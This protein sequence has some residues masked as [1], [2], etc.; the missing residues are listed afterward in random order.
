MNPAQDANT[1][2]DRETDAAAETIDSTVEPA[3]RMATANDDTTT[4]NPKFKA[5]VSP[6]MLNTG[7]PAMVGNAEGTKPE[8]KV[9][10]G[11]MGDMMTK[12]F[13]FLSTAT[14]ETLAGVGVCLA[15]VTYFV[16]GQLGLVLIGAFAGITAFISWEAKNPRFSQ[17]IK[18]EKGTETLARIL[19]FKEDLQRDAKDVSGGKQE[20][21]G[22]DL[23]G[24]E[25]FQP[26]TRDALNGLVD[27]VVRDYVKWWYSPIVPLDKAFPLACRKVLTSFLI[28]VS[29]RLSR[30]RPA[31]A[32]LDFLTNSSSIV[33]VLFSELSTAL[34]EEPPNDART[35]TD[36]VSNYLASNPDSNL[37]NL[38]NQ[39]QQAA[40]FRMVAE[41]LL[42]FLDRPTY[43]CDPARVF[44]REILAGVILEM[45]LK[46]CSKPEWINGWIVYLLEAGEPDFNQAIDVGMQ[47]GPEASK[48]STEGDSRN[49]R[50]SAD[51]DKSQRKENSSL[52][53]KRLSKA[54][55]EM[56]NAL[57]E[58]KKLNQMIADEDARRKKEAAAGTEQTGESKSA[59]EAS[60]RL[61]DA[62]KRNADTLDMQSAS[63][64]QGT[65]RQ[66]P[67]P[68]SP[69][70]NEK[71]HADVSGDE[72]SGRAGSIQTPLTP[73]SSEMEVPSQ[74]SSPLRENI[75]SQFT[76]FDQL[77]PPTQDETELSDSEPAYIPEPLTLH[78]ARITIHDDGMADG[79]SRIKNRPTSDYLIQV[80]PATSQHPGW[81]IVRKYADFE[82]LHEILARIAKISGAT[83]FTEHHSSLP[84]WRAHTKAS[85]SGELERYCR[86]A[87]QNKSLAASEG[88]KRFLEKDVMHTRSQSKSG[89][90]AFESM[91]KNVFGV[92]T[93][94]PKGVADGGKAVV[95][96][97][98]GV[99]GNFGLGS[100]KSTNSP[101]KQL[102][103]DQQQQLD[104]R[105][106]AEVSTPVSKR[107]S[108]PVPSP[109]RKDSGLSVINSGLISRDSMDSQRS[110][111]ISVQPAKVAPMERRPSYNSLHEG[112]EGA[113][114]DAKSLRP[115]SWDVT[116]PTS[117]RSS[118]NHSRA[119][120]LAPQRSPSST[121]LSGMRLP[122]LPDEIPDDYGT[123]GK[124]GT[125]AA[126]LHEEYPAA[127]A[128]PSHSAPTSG[129]GRPPKRQPRVS[130]PL[131]EQETSVAVELMF[132]VITELYTL[133]PSAWNIRRTLLAAAKSF[134]LRPGNPSLESIRS[135]IQGSVLDSAASDE[136]M[137][138]QLRKLR[139]N[140]VPTEEELAAWPAELTEEEKVK[141]RIKARR[142]LIQSGVPV[143]LS[144][145][146]GQAATS[147]ALGRVFD[148]L[149]VEDVA[150]GLLFGIMLQAVRTIT[151]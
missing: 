77:V 12:I 150:R 61:A 86:D 96:G 7:N 3:M 147:E 26:E 21:Q 106:S 114:S 64:P 130:A 84:G 127:A 49:G 51:L 48:S 45:T 38:L 78:N 39:K 112:M 146:M 8:S 53:K 133:S 29:N 104:T 90:E 27:A 117:A 95:D 55:E 132:A 123:P 101:L 18:A 109:S 72:S 68:L 100:R 129:F 74:P 9:D 131:T 75:T 22:T 2:S 135:L 115:D 14:P 140:S 143:A 93:S 30:K 4:D 137:A 52:H 144:G 24:F 66:V 10:G 5:A 87:C 63:V 40:K 126:A 28:S 134:L 57:E 128:S 41:D 34:T 91:G 121:S 89:F 50:N 94:A 107:H 25:D 43:D 35:V 124:A 47:T 120:S 111:V 36:S 1:S 23:K 73:G 16:L 6:T 13:Q 105:T 67:E 98:T 145:V 71:L 31:D 116:S 103:E 119:S 136:G 149:Q 151:H 138:T 17:G 118:I 69:L 33:I 85:L 70:P 102:P 79:K 139:E 142:L 92:L 62:M 148:C 122:P 46:S 42:V 81:M 76:S 110:S 65:S 37:A 141:L 80:E 125:K 20:D 54:D 88:M 97:V 58:M 19:D 59:A 11:A 56:E 60:S 108:M 44:L 83:A 82:Q 15:A 32:F 113:A 99:L